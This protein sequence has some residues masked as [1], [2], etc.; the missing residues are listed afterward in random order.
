MGMKITEI[1]IGELADL[2]PDSVEIVNLDQAALRCH[3]LQ[4]PELGNITVFQN[5]TGDGG[6]YLVQ[7]CDANEST[8]HYAQ[9][10]LSRTF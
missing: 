2:L 8:H 9:S 6:G 3:I 4:H 10:V 7:T 5:S 1:T